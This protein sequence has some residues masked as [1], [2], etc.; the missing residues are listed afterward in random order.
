MKNNVKLLLLTISYLG[1]YA[2]P[3]N[4]QSLISIQGGPNPGTG[5]RAAWYGEKGAFR[6]GNST[7]ANVFN[8]NITNADNRSIIG[9][10]SAAFGYGVIAYGD[11]SF[12]LVML[13]EQMDI[14]RQH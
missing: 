6:A 13:P 3:A 9:L 11:N 12:A 10:N 8:A 5:Y 1:F 7:P 14:V 2:G 4:A